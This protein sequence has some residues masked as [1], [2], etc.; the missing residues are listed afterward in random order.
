[1]NYSKN[2][3]AAELFKSISRKHKIRVTPQR[4]EIFKEL[5][6]SY[7]H[8]STN[9]IYK[10]V[11]LSLPNISFDTVYRTLLM[12]AE[13]GIVRTVEGTGDETRFEPN[14]EAHHHFRCLKCGRIIDFRDESL[15][16]I[17]IPEDIKNRFK[18]LTKRV[19]VEGLCESCAEKEKF[20]R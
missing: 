3:D 20:S 7:N 10:K 18:V 13:K 2:K 6:A 16:D 15:N 11:K 1:M 17:K 12:F 4:V 14:L 9:S 8:P 5:S 19:V